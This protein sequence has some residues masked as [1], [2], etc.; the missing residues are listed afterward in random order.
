MRV[1][2]PVFYNAPHAH[3]WRPLAWVYGSRVR[4]WRAGWVTLEMAAARIGLASH[5]FSRILA[6]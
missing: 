5:V 4:V 1:R 6:V 3:K 2:A